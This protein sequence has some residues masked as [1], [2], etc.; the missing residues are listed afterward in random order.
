MTHDTVALTLPVQDIEPSPLQYRRT[1]SEAGMA[2]L[3]A[4]VAQR[5]V[6]QRVR[7]RPNP[8]GAL[9]PYQLVFGHRRLEAALRA[10]LA[11]IPADGVKTMHIY[12]W[13]APYNGGWIWFSRANLRRCECGRINNNNT[14]WWAV[15][16]FSGRITI[17]TWPWQ[18]RG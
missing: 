5:G 16:G 15:F 7:V 4:D 2:E 8:D 1:F 6:L 14:F 18:R 11:T 13:N 3:V 17:Q 10:G 12:L 9:Q